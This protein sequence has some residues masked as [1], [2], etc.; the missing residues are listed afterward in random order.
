MQQ[1]GIDVQLWETWSR[2]RA[3]RR[4]HGRAGCQVCGSPNRA[5]KH[6]AHDSPAIL[7]DPIWDIICEIEDDTRRTAIL[8]IEERGP[9]PLDARAVDLLFFETNRVLDSVKI[10][11]KPVWLVQFKIGELGTIRRG[12]PNLK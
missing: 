11:H 10:N 1:H 4:N 12:D 5:A 9:N 3:R 7:Q 6:D 8:I 2:I